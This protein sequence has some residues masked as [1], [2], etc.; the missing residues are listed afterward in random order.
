M[1]VPYN[2]HMGFCVASLDADVAVLDGAV[3]ERLHNPMGVLHGGVLAGIA[4]SAMGALMTH[5]LEPG[6]RCTNVDVHIRF[7]QPV[8]AGSIRAEARFTRR[9]RSASVLEATVSHDGQVVAMA[10]ST[11][12]RRASPNRQQAS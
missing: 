9:G 10:T 7:L 1:N 3:D 4:D 12:L 11:F 5:N 2:D 8:V 6:E